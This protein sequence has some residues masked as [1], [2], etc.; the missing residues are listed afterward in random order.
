MTLTCFFF[1]IGKKGEWEGREGGKEKILK[2]NN[3]KN[4]QQTHEC[5]Q[6]LDKLPIWHPY[7]VSQKPQHIQMELSFYSNL[8]TYRY[9]HVQP[10]NH[11][12]QIDF[13]L[14]LIPHIQCVSNNCIPTCSISSRFKDWVQTD[15]INGSLINFSK[16]RH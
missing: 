8:F 15:N 3:K 13:S 12:G 5:P 10:T 7:L 11:S 16:W 2:N 9:P 14:P 1:S 4:N 6:D